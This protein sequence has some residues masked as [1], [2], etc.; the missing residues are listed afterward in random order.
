MDISQERRLVTDI[1]GPKSK[2]LLE[3]RSAAVPRGVF[4]TAPIFVEAASGAILRDVDGNSLIDLGAG[5]A[6]LNVGNASPAVVEAVRDQAEHFTH[7]CFH[8]TMHEPYI[9]LAERLNDLVPGDAPHM[10]MFANS[11]AEAIENAV[12]IARYFT[13]RPAVVVFDH[14]FHGRTQLAMTM[15]AKAM[16]YRQG[17]GPTAPEVYRLPYSYPYRCPTGGTTPEECA[18]RC[19]DYAIAEIEKHIGAANVACLVVEPIQ[20]EGGFVV[21]GPGFLPRLAEYCLDHGIL[22]VA[23]EVQTGFARTG[24]MFGI[25]HEGVVPDLVTTAKALAGGMPLGGVTGRAEV[26]ESVHVGGI[27]GTFGGNPISCAAGLAVLE[28][29]E[30]EGLVERANVIGDVMRERL[31]DMA[32]RYPVIGEVRGRG[33]MIAMELV[34]DRDS[35]APAKGASST[36]I[37]ECYRQGVVV[38]KAGTY[39]NVIRLLPPL[40]IGEDLLNEGLDVLEKAVASV[41]A[42]G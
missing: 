18:E 29:I 24:K 21:P 42:A 37:E 2:E 33:A 38:L 3:R 35:K 39:D 41:G 23:D 28:T 14:A 5:L 25:E 11:G 12:K 36:V 27:G 22:F 16:P 9:V 8:V 13:K 6:V 1:P 20:G 19:A 10:T 17:L 32:E 7:T 30:R 40:T 26:M 34:E 4:F 31:L 15:T